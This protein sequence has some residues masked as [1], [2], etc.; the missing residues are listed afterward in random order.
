M[1]EA[2]ARACAAAG[3]PGLVAARRTGRVEAI[4]GGIE[5]GGGG[6]SSTTADV[7][8]G[9]DCDRMMREC[10]ERF[11]EPYAVFANAGY[12][13]KANV[14]ETS[15][16]DFRA[17]YETNLFGTWNV[18]KAAI[19]GMVERGAGHVVI[20]S[21]S[22]GK[23]S[24]P[25]Y[26]AYCGTKA[27]QWPIAHAINAE[28]ADRGVFGTSVHPIGTKTEI[29]DDVEEKNLSDWMMQSPTHVAKRIVGALRR[30]RLEVWPSLPSRAFAAG[31]TL[32]PG[33]FARVQKSIAKKDRAR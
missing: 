26:A 6:A 2:A 21:S 27:A 29:F 32:V 1:G 4:A 11:G 23:V 25:A 15:D 24:L 33:V 18:V 13:I 30:P 5:R 17:I 3:M 9:E 8:V 12:L 14:L 20:C 10:G 16:E 7:T 28:Y 31:A 22:I 19:P